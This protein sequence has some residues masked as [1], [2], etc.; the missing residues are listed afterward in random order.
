MKDQKAC[1]PGH[2][3]PGRLGA[4]AVLKAFILL[5]TVQVLFSCAQGTTGKDPQAFFPEKDSLRAGPGMVVILPFTNK[6]GE[7]G[8]AD[9]VRESFYS[10]FSPKNFRDFEITMTDSLLQ[11]L[12]GHMGATWQGMPPRDLCRFFHS[13]YLVQGEVQEYQKVFLGVYSQIALTVGLEVVNCSTGETVWKKT[14]TKRSHEGGVP[15]GLWGLVPAAVRSGLHMTH[16][17]TVDLVDR[18]TRDL[19]QSIPEPSAAPVSAQPVE[20]QAASF[21]DRERAVRTAANLSARGIKTRVEP[22]DLRGRTFHRVIVGPFFS[23]AEA[24]DVKS[25]LETEEGFHP[26]PFP[27]SFQE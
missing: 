6:T 20:L 26:I 14:L 13:D 11:S 12:E 25:R 19:A 9:L 1:L 21:L 16:Q 17:R 10:H 5:L 7:P 24:E 8:I 2:S 27:R 22:V 3:W 4:T 18:L 23:P 15:F